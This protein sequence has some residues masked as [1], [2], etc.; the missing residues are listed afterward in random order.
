MAC[1]FY[2]QYF[3]MDA[4][5]M[6]FIKA[7]LIPLLTTLHANAKGKWGKMNAQQMV[8]HLSDFFRVST[9]QL[10]FPLIT[11]VENLPKFK[12]FLLSDKDFRENTSA[13]M[14]PEEPLATV[15]SSMP[16]AIAELE[17]QIIFFIE[18][19]GTRKIITSLHPVF[20]ELDFDEWVLLHFK[21]VTHHARQF[22]L[23]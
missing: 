16:E 21:H 6:V 1:F 3:F 10:H 14:L 5:K 17:R 22:G 19:F 13:P 20:G 12:G 2:L 9:N 4:Q 18:Q 23:L 11:P 15:C 7:E 8:E